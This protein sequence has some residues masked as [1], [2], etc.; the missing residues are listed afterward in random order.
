MGKSSMAMCVT[1][2]RN[3]QVIRR[4]KTMRTMWC[5]QM[6]RWRCCRISGKN[7]LI[8]D[9]K[10]SSFRWVSSERKFWEL[11]CRFFAR[12]NR[13][14]IETNLKMFEEVS[15]RKLTVTSDD[16]TFRKLLAALLIQ[17]PCRRLTL[18]YLFFLRIHLR[19]LK[20]WKTVFF[21]DFRSFLLSILKIYENMCNG[22]KRP[23]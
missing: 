17:F 16:F 12:F 14:E 7:L 20:T 18:V 22:W 11:F 23:K 10:L 19:E 15:G 13:R 8:C 9:V 21:I 2:R 4:R 3:C 5:W 6:S 1:A